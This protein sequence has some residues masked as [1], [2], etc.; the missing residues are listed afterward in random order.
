MMPPVSVTLVKFTVAAAAALAFEGELMA[1]KRLLPEFGGGASVWCATVLFFQLTLFAAYYGTRWLTRTEAGKANLVLAVLGLS[2]LLTLALPL[3]IFGW[4][5]PELQPAASLLP[6]GGL[7][8]GLFCATPLLHRRQTDRSDFTI[9]AWSNAGALLGLLAYPF[10]VEPATDLTVQNWV[11]AIGGGL[12]C[13]LGLADWRVAPG[14]IPERPAS[15]GDQKTRWQWWLLPAV[16]SA[17]M[18]AATN[19]LSFEA[20]AGPLTWALP[21]ALFLLTCIWAFSGNR[22]SFCGPM[23]TLGLLALVISHFIVDGRSLSLILLLLTAAGATMLCCHVWLAESRNENTHGFYA[24][25]AAGGVIGTA[26]MVLVIPHVTSGPI[27]FPILALATLTIA[28]YR[29]SGRLM[30]P[31]LCTV[32]VVAIGA[33]VAAESSGRVNEVARAR[34]LYGCWRVTRQPGTERYRLINNNTIHA[35]EN[36]TNAAEVMS[37]YLP[38]TGLGQLMQRSK[39]NHAVLNIGV[40]GLGAGTFNTFLRPDDS[41]CYYEIDAKAEELARTWFTYLRTG[42]TRVVIGDGRKSLENE[43][44]PKFDIIILDAFTG[45]AIPAHLLTRE[46]GVVYQRRL[47]DDGVLAIH[48][49]NRHVDLLPVAKG[50]ARSM[51]LACEYDVTG[52]V[53]WAILKPG[54]PPSVGRVL[55]WTDER[56]SIVPV[57]RPVLQTQSSLPENW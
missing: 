14:Y 7:A 31:L 50:L 41:I 45:D 57:L 47:K 15:T 42:R 9:Y 4:L 3:P 28:G 40:V 12:I 6:F 33:T 54:N 38:E 53:K 51:G 10:L 16:S 39:L 18:L 11:W 23:A 13:L 55:E 56:N 20:S 52:M 34:T 8:V 2:G 44:G 30:R 46:A 37:Y 32:A 25:T 21:L 26:V 1:G 17:T 43:S 48:I 22:G 27:E 35:E 24:A 5:P 36:R 19:L 29:W 49:T